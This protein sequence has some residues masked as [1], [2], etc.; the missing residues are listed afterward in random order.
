MNF[1]SRSSRNTQTFKDSP[2]LSGGLSAMSVNSTN[3]PGKIR[4]LKSRKATRSSPY[5]GKRTTSRL[6]SMDSAS[7]EWDDDGSSLLGGIVGN[8]NAWVSDK[9]VGIKVM[10][11]MP[12][13]GLKLM[14]DSVHNIVIVSGID[15]AGQAA[16]NGM[17][18][19]DQV[20]AIDALPVTSHV[21]ALQILET[22]AEGRRLTLTASGSTRAV[23][24]NKL[25]GDLGMTCCGA[26]HTTRGVLLKRIGTGSL[27]EAASIYVGDTIISV[28]EEL[29]NTHQE[30][31]KAMNA[32]TDEV[33]LVMWGQSTEVNLA[34]EGILGITL[35]NHDESTDGPGVKIS[36]LDINGRAAK[37][38]LSSGDTLM[39]VNGIICADHAQAVA[40]LQDAKVNANG[41][42]VVY[43]SKYGH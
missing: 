26:P 6:S 35:T 36:K 4:V 34:G 9:H 5:G 29:V 1:F 21:T 37:M 40:L 32:C 20:L 17:L 10:A 15:R 7:A 25:R 23:T 39:S 24:L 3:S 18:V 8:S 22:A 42:K 43:M 13:H 19:G 31:V 11:G 41:P 12:K 27:A 38:G 14:T 16:Q 28:N 2:G 30:A 33:R